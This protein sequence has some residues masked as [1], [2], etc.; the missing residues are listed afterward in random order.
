MACYWNKGRFASLDDFAT[1]IELAHNLV[2]RRTSFGHK[3]REII[4]GRRKLVDYLGTA[5]KLPSVMLCADSMPMLGLCKTN[6]DSHA[7]VA[8]DKYFVYLVGSHS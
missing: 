8:S 6:D 7:V 2:D 1:H 4:L 5:W 3:E